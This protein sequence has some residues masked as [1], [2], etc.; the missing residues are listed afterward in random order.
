MLPPICHALYSPHPQFDGCCRRR[1]TL[2]KPMPLSIP[3]SRSVVHPQLVG[4]SAA[5]PIR[6]PRPRES[7]TSRCAIENLPPGAPVHPTAYSD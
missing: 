7:L 4:P 5:P 6:M 1:A 3:N 2:F